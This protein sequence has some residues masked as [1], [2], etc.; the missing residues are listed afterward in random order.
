M[1]DDLKSDAFSTSGMIK[2]IEVNS[3][4]QYCMINTARVLPAYFEG[5]VMAV[6]K[7]WSRHGRPPAC[8]L[9]YVQ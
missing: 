4:L 6:L 5:H 1:F 7:S 8:R 9:S 2:T 3:E